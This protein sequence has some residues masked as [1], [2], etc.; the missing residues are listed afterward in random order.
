MNLY[1]KCIFAVLWAAVSTWATAQPAMPAVADPPVAAVGHGALI[2]A[3]GRDIEVTPEFVLAAQRHYLDRLQT[4]AAPA[5]KAGLTRQR[6][7]LFANQNWNSTDQVLAQSA[8]LQSYLAQLQPA[9]AGQVA[10]ID[11]A[12]RH[13]L[14]QTIG[15]SR[16]GSTDVSD[17][18]LVPSPRLQRLLDRSR[19]SLLR[20]TLQGGAAYINEC[21]AAGVPI[22][23][24][25][26]S[27]SWVSRGVLDNE[28]ISA[29]SEAEVFVFQSTSPRGICFALPRSNGNTISL[30]GIICQGNDTSKSC[31]WDNQRNKVQFNIAKGTAV[32][33]SG[34]AGGA[35]LNG[36]TGGV[37]SDCHAGNNP[38]IIHPGTVLDVGAILKPNGWNQ[39]LVH[40]S[41][42]QNAGPTNRLAGIAI[43]AG[44]GSCTACHVQAST[45]GFPEISTATPSY[46]AAVLENAI[47]RTMPPGGAGGTSYAKHIASLRAACKEAPKL[48]VLLWAG[49][50]W[51]HTGMPCTGESCPGW[52]KLDNNVRTVA[53][54]A[55]NG[56]LFQL[57]NDG[58][59]WQS[60]GAPC[61]D[62]SCPGWQKLDNNPRTIS[63]AAGGNRLYQ[64][65]NDGAIWQH[66]GVACSGD[67]CPGWQQLDH[68]PAT[69]AIVASADQLF[70][71]HRD[72]RVWEYTGTA[73][74]GNVCSGWRMLDNNT[75]TTAIAASAGQLF[76]QH[77][78][79]RIWQY[80]GTA[81]SSGMCPGWRMLDNNPRTADLAAN[82]GELLQR[83]R[84]GLVW[85]HNGTACAGENCPGW[86]KL[87][88]N[89]RTS[90]IAGSAFQQHQDGRIWQSTGAA[91]SGNSCPGWRLLDNNPRTRISAPA[92]GDNGRLYQLHA[93]KVYQLHSDGAIWQSLGAPCVGDACGSWQRMDNNPQTRSI[94]ASG[95]KLFQ[96]HGNGRIWQSDGRPCDG[97][98]CPGWRAL[99]ANPRTKAIA[100]AGGQL[101]QLH[102][103]GRV[104]RH[105]G[106]A[107]QGTSCPGWVLL[108]ANTRTVQ[109]SAG[110][111]QLYQRHVDGKLWRHTGVPCSS[112]TVCPG[113]T[114]VDNNPAT[115]QIVAGEGRLYQLHQGGRIFEH[116]GQACS[117][118][119][120]PGWR[121][122]DS[123]GAT[124]SIAAAGAELY[125]MH[126]NGRV[127]AHTGEACT[128]SGGNLR[129]P[130]WRLL[131]ANPRTRQIV[132]AD[133]ILYQRHD[134]GAVWR[135][136]GRA[137]TS[138]SSCPGWQRMDNNTRTSSIEAAQ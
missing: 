129:C 81:C 109:I 63:I 61:V 87:D 59:I 73:C 7:A 93:P 6:S 104:W 70:Q 79:G 50:L 106:V 132:A 40:P 41:W 38:F 25:W 114:M 85:K 46:C 135:S 3:A 78:D 97:D 31:F 54:A 138:T 69:A 80:T 24:D 116:T 42:P 16:A 65:H 82:G 83:H 21:R 57:H 2:D 5:T 68:N 103:D 8:L 18:E 10:S 115:R 134:S 91:C 124:A 32:P 30:L 33:L 56:R 88:N 76:Q 51:S 113:W 26:G 122:L 126:R 53:Y 37:C 100:S 86:V 74:S 117:A 55:G 108:D 19:P 121:L 9:D 98:S 71:L 136:D 102:S 64:L 60:T 95:G 58:A 118:N 52:Q 110:G 22:P 112:A 17:R 4:E 89:P 72:G 127:W 101:Y 20:S 107:C 23:P 27:A 12:L 11:A 49:A 35:D 94:A 90:S 14:A 131:D 128:G 44:E 47:A 84:D 48:N 133:G 67:N 29:A 62:E 75:R 96:L 15:T 99:D 137:C 28:F 36:G 77:H 13:R 120:C 130:G 111:Q 123:N 45:G 66:T 92:D 43:G 105:T 1:L 125:Q 39:P 119:S 34:F